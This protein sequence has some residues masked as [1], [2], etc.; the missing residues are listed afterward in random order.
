[1]VVQE[2]VIYGGQADVVNGQFSLSFVVPKDINYNVGVGK[3]S[4]Y[5]A[6][7]GHGVDANGYQLSQVGGAYTGAPGDTKPPQIRPCSWT[8]SSLPSAASRARTPRCW[9]SS[10]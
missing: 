6:D 5:A 1:M 7:A 9:P 10:G 4:L 8:A 2:S 3:I